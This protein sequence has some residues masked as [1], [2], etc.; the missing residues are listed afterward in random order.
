MNDLNSNLNGLIVFVKFINIKFHETLSSGSW[1][2]TLKQMEKQTW[3][4]LHAFISCTSYKEHI[5]TKHGKNLIPY[6]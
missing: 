1:V 5:I 6:F 4:A 2:E 3:P